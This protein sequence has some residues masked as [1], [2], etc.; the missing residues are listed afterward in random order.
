MIPKAKMLIFFCI[1]MLVSSSLLAQNATNANLP[2]SINQQD[3]NLNITRRINRNEPS[4]PAELPTQNSSNVL[5]IYSDSYDPI[6]GVNLDANWGES[7]V[8]SFPLIDGNEVMKMESFNYQ[9]IAHSNLNASQMEY[10]HI[11]VWTED[12]VSFQVTPIS[13]GFESLYELSPTLGEWNSYDIPLTEFPCDFSNLIQFKFDG[14]NGTTIYV[15]NLFYWKPATAIQADATLSDLQVNDVTI[16]GFSPSIYTY[17]VALPAG[18]SGR[19]RVTATAT[20]ELADYVIT[21]ATSIPGTTT[22]VVTSEDGENELTYSINFTIDVA[23]LVAAPTPTENAEDVLSVYS[24]AFTPISGVDLNPNWGQTTSMTFP[25]IEEDEVVKME[26]LNY[27]G[28]QYDNIDASLMEYLHIDVWTADAPSFQVTPI[29]PGAE[30]LYELSPT[31]G[32][33]NSFDIP[34]SEFPCNLANLYQL[35]YVGTAG[36]TVFIDNIYYWKNPTL[37]GT[38][39]TLSDLL[40]DGTT[41]EGFSAGIYEYDIELPVGSISV[42]TVTA[43]TNDENASHVVNAATE[44]PGTT[45]VVVTSENAEVQQSYTIN[46]T[47]ANANTTPLVAAPSPTENAEDVLSIYSGSYIAVD[48]L[49]LNPFWGQ[50]TTQSFPLIEGDE[51]LKMENFN[52]QGIEYSTL[53]ASLME[54][55]HIDIWTPDA[56]SVTITPISPGLEALYELSPTLGQWNSYD[57]PL[58]EFPCNFAQLF[59]FKFEG[60]DATTIFVDNLYYWKNPT[61]EGTDASLSNLLMNAS[62]I[63]GFASGIYEYDIELPVG[64]SEVPT[65]TATTSDLDASHVVVPATELPGTTTVTVTSANGQVEQDYVINFTVASS[66]TTPLVAAPTPTEESSNVLSI[67]S[68]AY[69]PIDGVNLDANWGESTVQ[70]YPLIEGDEVM[71]MENF[72]FQGMTHDAL[73]ASQ[74]QFI[75]VDVWTHD[76]PSFQLTPI[77]PGSEQVYELS[78]TLGEWNSFDIALTNFPCDFSNLIQFKFDGTDGSTVYIDNLYYWKAPYDPQNDATLSNLQVNGTSVDGFDSATLEYS[79]ELAEGTMTVPTVTATTTIANAT[80][81]ITDAAQL[82]GTTT[83]VVTSENEAVEKTYSIEFT[84][85]GPV[86]ASEYCH[87]YTTH[88]N[89]E[90]ETPSAIYLTISNIDE[91]SMYVEIESADDDAVDLL[92]VN[93]FS[94]GVSSEADTSV[95]GK[96][97]KTITWIEAPEDVEM[98][99]LWSKDSFA[100]NWMLNTFT[101][102]FAA[103]CS[104][105]LDIP[106][107]LEISINGNDVTITWTAV[108]G[109]D[110]YKVYSKSDPYAEYDL[111]E[112]GNLDGTSWTTSAVPSKKFFKVV[113]VSNE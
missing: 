29:S 94:G 62:T 15:D 78:P 35:K 110:T 64:T 92:L 41:I 58:T 10:L 22:V 44:L 66:I 73:D 101:V 111:D 32:Q 34:L 96:I 82:P 27:Q 83:V 21:N 56:E 23:P 99:I 98:Q 47:V 103:T 26:N 42:P 112:S 49:N 7:T 14:T 104:P 37:T 93:N 108:E 30:Q 86:P 11:D 54:Y 91:T 12:A 85:A 5:S 17:D 8:Q 105:T 75:H 52:Y 67:Y 107:D 60:T 3:N 1:I 45:T 20:N 18:S 89:I 48:G 61:V 77:S 6:T 90:A 57:I 87:Q 43:V 59:Q 100:G 13:P 9:G 95:P 70:T 84:L 46:F 2:N 39:A 88:L 79:V 63:D 28:M 69:T 80:Y 76:A 113:A 16:E 72:T 68:G 33:W 25:M 55:L 24:D 106:Q 19:P 74:M 4:A 38:D 36:A 31:L 53:D 97:R 65:V 109:A 50:T 51:V 102:P 81:I 40:V 71:K